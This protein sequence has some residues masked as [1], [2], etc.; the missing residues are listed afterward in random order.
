MLRVAQPEHVVQWQNE[1]TRNRANDG[2]NDI[3]PRNLRRG[4]RNFVVTDGA[5][6]IAK[7]KDGDAQYQ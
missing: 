1:I 7:S 3:A 4:A 5:S 2:K 6:F